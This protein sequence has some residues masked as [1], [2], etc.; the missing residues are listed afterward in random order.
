M[1]L[2]FDLVETGIRAALPVAKMLAGIT[3]NAWDDKAVAL[4]EATLSNTVLMDWLRSILSDHAV[5]VSTGAERSGAIMAAALSTPDEVKQAAAAAGFDW[6][7]VLNYLPM[8]V[9]L[10]LTVIGLRG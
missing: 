10:L 4:I 2:S 1:H 5:Q 6:S 3:T 9:R 8:I 7:S